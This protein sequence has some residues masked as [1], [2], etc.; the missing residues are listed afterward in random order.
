MNADNNSNGA[1]SANFEQAASWLS[2]QYSIDHDSLTNA[3]RKEPQ[4][5]VTHFDAAK[6]AKSERNGW[7]GWSV[8][9]LIFIPPIAVYTGYRAYD[10]HTKVAA[11]GDTLKRRVE[12]GSNKPDVNIDNTL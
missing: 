8:G 11:I 10:E 2:R 12:G 3:Y 5:L 9:W 6:D 1:L 7:V 4:S